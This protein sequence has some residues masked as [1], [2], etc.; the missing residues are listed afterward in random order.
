MPQVQ[1]PFFHESV[2]LLVHHGEDGSFGLIVNRPTDLK[3][4]DIL[5]GME[6]NW[7]GS[8]DSLA[9][10]GGPVQ[11]Q[12]GTVLYRGETDRTLEIEG[13]SEVSPGIHTTQNLSDLEA[14]A[15]T[16]P[17]GLRLVLGYAGWGEEQL[18]QEILRNDWITAPV[19]AELI[20][21]K[22]PSEVWPATL[23]SVGV[24]PATLP[25]WT[26]SNGVA[27]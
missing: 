21:S 11:P 10:F 26:D 14:L 9:F 20:F 7:K 18:V 4:V 2:V 15:N 24:N 19:S 22:E 13:A 5:D 27:N 17:A 16:P 6:L 8:P 12:Q 25:S 3:I 23:R 1:D